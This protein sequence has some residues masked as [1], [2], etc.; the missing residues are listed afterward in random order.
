MG[1]GVARKWVAK[2]RSAS[3]EGKA[4]RVGAATSSDG[5]SLVTGL[6][7]ARAT[8]GGPALD[9]PDAVVSGGAPAAALPPSAPDAEPPNSSIWTR[10]FDTGCSDCDAQ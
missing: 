6:G 8:A 4:A 10:S 5:S 9:D 1:V 7:R 2:S 3:F